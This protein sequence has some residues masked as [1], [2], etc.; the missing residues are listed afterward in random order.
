MNLKVSPRVSQDHVG[1]CVKNKEDQPFSQQKVI[2]RAQF[3][4]TDGIPSCECNI[5]A[6][7][8]RGF[9]LS[10]LSIQ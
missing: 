8:Q 7:K 6:C 1:G 4:S 5:D 10:V 3:V 2:K 9:I